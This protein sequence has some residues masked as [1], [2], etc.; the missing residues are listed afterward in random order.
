MASTDPVVHESDSELNNLNSSGSASN[1]TTARKKRVHHLFSCWTF[2]LT[3]STDA[4]ALNGGRASGSVT[5]QERQEYLLEHFQSCMANPDRMPN[6]VTF[7][8]A[9]YDSSIISYAL[10]EGI[11]ISI[12]LLGFVQTRAHTNCEI[13]T[14]QIW[15]PACWSP[16]PGGL[17]SNQVFQRREDPNNT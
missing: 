10:P 14:M 11:S 16:V 12:P 17:S 15:F 9:H 8:E 2:Q 1:S 13:S 5:L 3:I 4:A 7:V 6:F